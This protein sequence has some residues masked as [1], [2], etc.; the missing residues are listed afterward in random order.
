MR[1]TERELADLLA[2]KKPTTNRSNF[3]LGRLPPGKMNRTEEAYAAHLEQLKHVGDV[4]WYK[5][6]GIKLRLADNTFL[7]IDFPVLSATG[8][9][10]MRE[11]KGFLRD[12][13]NVKLKVAASMYPFKFILVRRKK[14]GWVHTDI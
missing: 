9:L 12:D 8:I 2:Q 14:S 1:L 4:L 3:A 13:A 11:V 7:T 5:F 6:E 10:E